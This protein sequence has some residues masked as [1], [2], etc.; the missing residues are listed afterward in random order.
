MWGG[1]A[2]LKNGIQINLRKLDSVEIDRVGGEKARLG[3]GVLVKKLVDDLAKAGK[4]AGKYA[5]DRDTSVPKSLLSPRLLT[6][7]PSTDR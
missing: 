5:T 2:E 7:Y 4:Y 3:G 6:A 1:L